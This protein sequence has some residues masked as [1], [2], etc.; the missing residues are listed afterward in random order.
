M[1][2]S[3]FPSLPQYIY[4][5]FLACSAAWPIPA[6]CEDAKPGGLRTTTQSPATATDPTIAPADLGQVLDEISNAAKSGDKAKLTAIF[7]SFEIPDYKQWFGENFGEEEGDKLAAAYEK[8]LVSGYQF[9]A[10][11]LVSA[12]AWNGLIIPFALPSEHVE[13][14]PPVVYG[15]R[16]S[17][18][19]PRV[20]YA[21][22]YFWKDASGSVHKISFGYLTK[23]GDNYR[24]VPAGLLWLLKLTRS[25]PETGVSMDDKLLRVLQMVASAPPPPPPMPPPPPGLSQN[26][27]RI[28]Q[29]GTVTAQFL[30]H[31]VDPVYPPLAQQARISGTVR[32][33]AIIDKDGSVIELETI[34]GHPLLVPSAIDAVKQWRYRPTLV[35]GEPVQVD[36]T[37]DVIYQLKQ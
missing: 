16:A 24:S 5:V 25:T 23:I 17:L 15:L 6:R 29:P 12:S 13:G 26:V 20:F 14:E 3:F 18:K 21:T 7:K 10:D 4:F 8:D 1:S 19:Q 35:D 28:T 22:G 33:H 11:Q 37:I 34:S 2:K 32:L 30:I 9:L 36:T 27:T 31:K